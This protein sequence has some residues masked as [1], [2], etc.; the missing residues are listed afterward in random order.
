MGSLVGDHN[1]ESKTVEGRNVEVFHQVLSNI[2]AQAMPD[3]IGRFGRE[4]HQAN[5]FRRVTI[6][7]HPANPLNQ[8]PSLSRTRAG[9]NEKR[10]PV[11]E[12]RL[13]LKVVQKDLHD[14][15]PFYDSAHPSL[16]LPSSA[17]PP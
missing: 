16:T 9:E 7:D 10:P 1:S 6:L 3:L 13:F 15:S 5:L 4:G 11:M 17:R 12:D 2:P 14:L 8:D